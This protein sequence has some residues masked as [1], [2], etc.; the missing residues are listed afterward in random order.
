MN[1]P[2]HD[3]IKHLL[4]Q[5]HISTHQNEIKKKYCTIQGVSFEMVE[6]P[7]KGG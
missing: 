6:K 1:L 3:T 5:V 4:V 2:T 7:R